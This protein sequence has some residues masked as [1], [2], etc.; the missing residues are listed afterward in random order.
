MD[1]LQHI[2]NKNTSA[3][4]KNIALTLQD[5]LKAGGKIPVKLSTVRYKDQNEQQNSV[6]NSSSVKVN[7]NTYGN[8]YKAGYNVPIR[9]YNMNTPQVYGDTVTNNRR[10]GNRK[11]NKVPTR[12]VASGP[13]PTNDRTMLGNRVKNHSYNTNNDKS[14]KFSKDE[15]YDKL[16]DNKDKNK[17]N[18]DQYSEDDYED[19]DVDKN[20]DN[21]EPEYY[22]YYYYDYVDSGIDISHELELEPLPTPM[23]R[24]E[25]LPTPM[26]RVQ[27]ADSE[28]QREGFAQELTIDLNLEDIS[29]FHFLKT[30]SNIS[31]NEQWN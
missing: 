5:K 10:T 19:Y 20:D 15:D 12:D 3:S 8:P 14:S 24:V 27:P 16:N 23:A 29:D 2:L 18:T 17:D 7:K 26:A 9:K 25:P 30:E 6:D 13:D 28:E 31:E 11:S 4:Y 1:I 22:Y 21:E